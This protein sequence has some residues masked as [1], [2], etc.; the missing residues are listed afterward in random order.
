[1]KNA[2]LRVFNELKELPRLQQFVARRLLHIGNHAWAT[3][4]TWGN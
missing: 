4:A 2:K 1:M 3:G